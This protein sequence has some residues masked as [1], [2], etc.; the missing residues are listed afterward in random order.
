MMDNVDIISAEEFY[1]D[2]ASTCCFTGHRRRDLPFEGDISKQGVKNLISTVHLLC[3]EAYGRGIR[4]FITG[5][6][7]GSD[8]ICGSVIMDLMHS[9]DHPGIELIC[10]LPYEDQIREIKLPKDRYIYS[11]L[12]RMASA[13]VVT[14][15]AD[16]SGRYR[17]RNK[18]MVD[19]SSEL[20]A[21]YKEKQ[22]GSGTL[23]TINMAKRN[24]LDMHVIE[25][26]KNPQFYYE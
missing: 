21:I 16:D 11:L 5:M 2:K 24:G 3:H 26:D 9:E 13:V 14:G 23:Q 15:N 1:T 8:I 18:F 20:I 17:R 4:T 25:L 7:E 6:A 12:L 22:R 10:A 19:N